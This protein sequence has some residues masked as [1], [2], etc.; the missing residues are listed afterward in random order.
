MSALIRRGSWVLMAGAALFACTV[1]FGSWYTVDQRER[2]VVLRNGK[3]VG[4]ATPGL[5]FKLPFVDSVVKI[6]L[7]Q[8]IEPY[9]K[10]SSYSRDQQTAV[11]EMSVNYRVLEDQVD[12]LY[13][14]YGSISGFV[15]RRITPKVL[16]EFKNVF[17]TYNAVTAI[18]QRARLNA[19]VRDAII[20]A[21]IADGKSPVIITDVQIGNVDFSDAYEKSIE[22]RMLAEVEVQRVLQNAEREKA[23]ALI[24]V[25]KAQAE[26]DATIARAKAEADAIML[27]GNA[28]ASAIQAR[29]KALG[30]NPNLV[31][32]TQAERWNG[33]LPTTMLPG[34][35][36]PMLTVGR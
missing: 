24:T 3:L 17:G 4:V 35:S 25:T 9:A 5:N 1:F 33:V 27:R 15:Q 16:E 6:S 30:E 36:V 12:D 23:T 14:N 21:I 10:L 11:V 20:K 19:E 18:Q 32:L 31:Q 13:V 28:E 26:A 34:G 22:Q 8:A 29:A 7:E 2:G